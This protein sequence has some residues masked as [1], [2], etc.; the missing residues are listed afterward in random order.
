MMQ[1]WAEMLNTGEKADSNNTKPLITTKNMVRR[2]LRTH[3]GCRHS[4]AHALEL[5]ADEGGEFA[6][7]RTDDVKTR[8]LQAFADLAR[9]QRLLYFFI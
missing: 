6:R 8:R 3:A 1:Q 5:R 7:R 4:R 2:L 9:C